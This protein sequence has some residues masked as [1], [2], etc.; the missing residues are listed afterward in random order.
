MFH[1]PFFYAYLCTVNERKR[2]FDGKKKYNRVEASEGSHACE[3]GQIPTQPSLT[4]KFDRVM[5]K[6]VEIPFEIMERLA[7]GKCVEGSLRRDEWT[8]RM[9]FRAY[10]RQPYVRHR[11][12]LICNLEHGWVKESKERIKVYESIPKVLGTARVMTVID[13]EAK[14]AKNALIERELDLLEF[15]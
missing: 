4:K 9:T 6:Y 5:R 7:E 14:E 8:G 11:D 15:C 3:N 2:G 13:R 1:A 12:R 10:N